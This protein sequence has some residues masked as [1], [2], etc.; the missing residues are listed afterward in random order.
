MSRKTS[1]FSTAEPRSQKD[2]YRSHPIGQALRS[3]HGRGPA[4]G[5]GEPALA[6]LA[7]PGL[8]RFNRRTA[9]FSVPAAPDQPGSAHDLTW[10]FVLPK[11]GP[12]LD[13]DSVGPTVWFGGPVDDPNSLF[14]QGFEELQFYPNAV[15]TRCTPHSGFEVQHSTGSWSVCSPRLIDP[16]H[17]SEAGLPRASDGSFSYGVDYPTTSDDFGRV[18]Q[19]ATT[20]ECDGAFGPDTTYCAT[21]VP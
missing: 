1:G 9:L 7:P 14:G 16:S 5:A 15:V 2:P 4:N 10:T 18:D 12:D 19:F 21:Q 3:K 13:V 8:A 17:G 6:P 11:N 20:T